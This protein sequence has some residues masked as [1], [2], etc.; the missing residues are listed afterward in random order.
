MTTKGL[1]VGQKIELTRYTGKLKEISGARTFVSQLL[2]QKEEGNLVIAMPM[3]GGKMV[4]FD[5]GDRYNMF[6]YT[7]AGL[8]YCIA[9]VSA[10]YRSG[11]L[12][13]LEMECASEIEKFQRRQFFRLN[14]IVDVKYRRA[15][16]EE[17]MELGTIIDISGGGV[18]F[19]G[20]ERYTA[21]DEL[22]V[23]FFLTIGGKLEKFHMRV[24]VIAS[25]PLPN[26]ERLYENRVEFMDISEGDREAIVK[27]VFEEERRRRKRDSSMR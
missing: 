21:G 14:C 16:A 24:R 17:A 22:F 12:F 18:R 20:G 23:E 10:R 1:S 6:F 3:E 9:Q 5:V 19:N 8:Y 26:R 25:T 7:P 13:M 11:A 27:Y 2:D 15:D 4:V